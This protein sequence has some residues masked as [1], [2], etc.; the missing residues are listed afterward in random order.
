MQDTGSAH[1]DEVRRGLL[2]LED[3]NGAAGRTAFDER[4]DVVRYPRL[5][6]VRNGAPTSYEEF[7]QEGGSLPVPGGS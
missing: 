5:F 4:G 7:K 1:P 2:G 3:F 6:I